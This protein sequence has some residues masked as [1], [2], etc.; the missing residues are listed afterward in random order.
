MIDII[1]VE[2][3]P[4]LA[5]LKLQALMKAIEPFAEKPTERMDFYYCH[6]DVT[7]KE[8]C[9]RCSRAIAAYEALNM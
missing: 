6:Y 5:T 1:W 9:G 4:R 3:N 8:E 2:K 7:T